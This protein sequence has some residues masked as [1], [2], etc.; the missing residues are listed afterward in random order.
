MESNVGLE[1]VS[2][3]LK[4]ICNG[5]FEIKSEIGKGTIVT[6]HIPKGD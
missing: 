6:M 5:T 2:K 4:I 1:N 3:R